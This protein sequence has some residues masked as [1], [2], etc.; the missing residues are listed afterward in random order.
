MGHGEPNHVHKQSSGHRSGHG[1]QQNARIPN[2]VYN[3]FWQY[4][5]KE[6][7]CNYGDSGEHGANNTQNFTACILLA[8]AISII[9]GTIFTCRR[10]CQNR[11]QRLELTFESRH[12]GQ[13]GYSSTN[14]HL[15][16]MRKNMFQT[17]RQLCCSWSLQHRL[18][19][20]YSHMQGAV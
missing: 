15:R 7:H 9:D 18:K 2:Q 8:I 10:D 12:V 14:R 4:S 5:R 11:S 17:N 3:K 13:I 16:R 1:A 19:S 6:Q 20:C